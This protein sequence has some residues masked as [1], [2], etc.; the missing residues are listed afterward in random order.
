LTGADSIE[1]FT[2][3]AGALSLLASYKIGRGGGW[4]R[5]RQRLAR[6]SFIGSRNAHAPSDRGSSPM[7]GP[8]ENARRYRDRVRAAIVVLWI[9]LLLAII[10]YA[11]VRGEAGFADL[12][13]IGIRL[14][15]E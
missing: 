6:R 3:L 1:S 11:E 14:V 13:D 15:T 12:E 4:T 10:G 5:A 9:L 7:S 2:R 8:I